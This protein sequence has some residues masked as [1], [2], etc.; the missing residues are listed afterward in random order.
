MIYFGQARCESLKEEWWGY[1]VVREA[2]GPEVYGREKKEWKGE[3]HNISS[4]YIFG[5]SRQLARLPTAKEIMSSKYR[6]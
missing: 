6:D 1:E 2:I 4:S 5:L 3:W